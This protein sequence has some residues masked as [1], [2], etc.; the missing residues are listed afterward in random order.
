M[1]NEQQGKADFFIRL[2]ELEEEQASFKDKIFFILH[3]EAAHFKAIESNRS[4]RAIALSLT[5]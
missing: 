5:L 3:Q 4:L 1:D 2:S